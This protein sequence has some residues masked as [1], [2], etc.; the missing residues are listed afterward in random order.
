ML[1]ILL[2]GC[3]T[4]SL[5]LIEENSLKVF[6]NKGLRKMKLQENGESYTMLNYINYIFC[7][8]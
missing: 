1:P 3:K 6:E 8:K 4:W 2:Y 7:L 5:T